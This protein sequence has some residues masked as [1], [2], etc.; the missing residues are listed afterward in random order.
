MAFRSAAVAL[1]LA[2]GGER[3][4]AF[5]SLSQSKFGAQLDQIRQEMR[6]FPTTA[7]DRALGFLWTLPADPTSDAGLGGGIAYAWD[8]SV[9]TTVLPKFREDMFYVSWLGEK[10]LRS[11]GQR[12]FDSWAANHKH[13]SFVD[14]TESCRALGYP[15]LTLADG[16]SLERPL[17]ECPLVELTI[18]TLSP[19][20]SASSVESGSASS[21]EAA[22]TAVPTYNSTFDFRYTN[23]ETPR[24]VVNGVAA[25]REVIQTY[26]GVISLSPSL[27]WYLDS[28]FCSGFHE[29]KKLGDPNTV[30]Q[31]GIA[32][33]FLVWGAA[34]IGITIRLI[35]S[36]KKQL[37]MA[38]RAG[39]HDRYQVFLEV[40]AKQSVLGTALRF[41]V[42][43]IPWPFYSSIFVSCWECYDFEA[44][45]T[46]E[47]G[48]ILGLG[49]PD[50]VP[51]YD[52]FGT[53]TPGEL[54]P[55]YTQFASNATN[56]YNALMAENTG[57]ARIPNASHCYNIWDYVQPNLPPSVSGINSVTAIR[58]SIMES[59]TTHNPT[60]C[61]SEDDLEGLNTLYP[62]CSG[63]IVTPICDK[64]DM[65]IGMLRMVSY[66]IFPA[67]VG[68]VLSII[69]HTSLHSKSQKDLKKA[70][71]AN[72]WL[73]AGRL[74]SQAA[75][76]SNAT[77]FTQADSK[78]AAA[79]AL[80]TPTGVEVTVM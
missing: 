18:T 27:C 56:M 74:S 50:L 49:H 65:N 25:P 42:I 64:S 12:A 47:I 29:L 67:V 17:E 39:L 13:I 62:V 31:V 73:R 23:G 37:S 10:D 19:S 68:L 32:I 69:L 2:A 58:P 53:L 52:E 55:S 40:F 38:L 60:V 20:V 4:L 79:K 41:V 8:P 43:L 54:D 28:Q 78:L 21:G 3:V 77:S 6:G 35:R 22:A 75:R 36:F 51:K 11:S 34:M 33:L 59:F 57:A 76:Q 61:I 44:A 45:L 80:D 14:V 72:L 16:S 71:A 48:H 30:Q 9:F 5:T 63:A 15:T 66:V 1:L 24:R 70:K 46:H 26:K 7:Q